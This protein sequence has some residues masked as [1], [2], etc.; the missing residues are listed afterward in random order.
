MVGYKVVHRFYEDGNLKDVSCNTNFTA[1]SSLRLYYKDGEIVIAPQGTMGIFIFLKKA[2]AI[3]F[4]RDYPD[5]IIKKVDLLSRPM[6]VTKNIMSGCSDI[7]TTNNF[8]KKMYKYFLGQESIPA[9]Y[10]TYVCRK[11]RV[12]EDVKEA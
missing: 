4:K 1:D 10:G 7:L 12:I 2:D 11:I 6:K 8:I 3:R 9:P 5:W